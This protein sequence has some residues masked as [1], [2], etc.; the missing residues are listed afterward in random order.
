[1]TSRLRT[2]T[3]AAYGRDRSDYQR[4]CRSAWRSR[5]P[6]TDPKARDP[7]KVLAAFLRRDYPRLGRRHGPMGVNATCKT[8]SSRRTTPRGEDDS[9]WMGCMAAA[10]S[11]TAAQFA[12]MNARLVCVSS[13]AVPKCN[14]TVA[15]LI[16]ITSSRWCVTDKSSWLIVAVIFVGRARLQN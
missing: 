5:R 11:A 13:A 14:V 2:S 15:R 4:W 1:M 8:L 9:H 7:S 16:L 3:E 6:S 10:R 12:H